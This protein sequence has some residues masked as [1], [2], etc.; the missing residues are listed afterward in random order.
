MLRSIKVQ[1][2][3]E[4]DLLRYLL[5]WATNHSTHEALEWHLIVQSQIRLIG[6]HPESYPPS[7]ENED[8]PYEI[9]DAL[10][11]RENVVVTGPFSLSKTIRLLFS[12]C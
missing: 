4:E 3:A 9:R 12:A 1:P 2:E 8:F 7:R 11:G 10:I 5:W 6:S